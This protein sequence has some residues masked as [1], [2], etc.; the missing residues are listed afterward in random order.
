MYHTTPS[1]YHST[2]EHKS[3][4][5]FITFFNLSVEEQLLMKYSKSQLQ[6]LLLLQTSS[7]TKL[8]NTHLLGLLHSYRVQKQ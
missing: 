6:G 8:P 5:G 2:Y 1:L 4:Q 7:Y 3:S